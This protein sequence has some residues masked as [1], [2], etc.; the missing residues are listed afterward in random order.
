[1]N[2]VLSIL[3]ILAG[4]VGILYFYN[5]R[6]KHSV[7]SVFDYSM[8]FKGYAFSIILIIAGIITL[9]RW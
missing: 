7:E 6:L 2:I 1:M 3:L 9:I 4:V 8:D 5:Y